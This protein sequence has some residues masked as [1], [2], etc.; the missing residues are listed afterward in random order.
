MI[1]ERN[2]YTPGLLPYIRSARGCTSGMMDRLPIPLTA[3]GLSVFEI[4]SSIDNADVLA[5][6]GPIVAVFLVGGLLPRLIV[7][8][9]T[10]S[11]DPIGALFA[12]ISSDLAV[13]AAKEATFSTGRCTSGGGG[14]ALH[15]PGQKGLSRSRG[16]P[17]SYD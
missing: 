16:E 4:A 12:T 9:T 7:R 10:P 13:V 11:P 14:R 3:A 6:G 5:T 2:P 15:D 8:A 1:Y 17:L